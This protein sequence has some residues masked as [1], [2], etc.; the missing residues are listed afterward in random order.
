MQVLG[1]KGGITLI[2]VTA[3]SYDATATLLNISNVD[4]TFLGQDDR[5]ILKT[6]F[7]LMNFKRLLQRIF[8]DE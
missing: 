7:D 8:M 3:V 1:T 6:G 4:V 2:N 5:I